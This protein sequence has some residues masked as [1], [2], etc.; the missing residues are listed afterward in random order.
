[1]QNPR[2]E[3]KLQ[4]R[5]QNPLQVEG[6]LLEASNYHQFLSSAFERFKQEGRGFSY[7]SFARKANIASRSF[8]R[9]VALEKKRLTHSS[10]RA[11]AGALG[12]TGDLR[13]FFLLLVERDEENVRSSK[14][15]PAQI[16]KQ[17]DR[18]RMMIAKKSVE[19]PV[20]S[21][22]QDIF[23]SMIWLKIYSASGAPDEGSTL[24]EIRKRC[25]QLEINLKTA[26]QEMC[27]KDIL[28]YN[29]ATEKYIPS[30]SHYIFE[31]LKADEFF[32]S[33]YLHC[34]SECRK[35]VATRFKS[36][37]DLY[38]SSVFSV[39]SEL[40]PELRVKLR[41]VLQ[42]FTETAESPTGSSIANL[43]VGFFT[44]L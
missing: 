11:F 21:T 36:E 10:A 24:E 1:M 39:R 5:M 30:C 3:S 32:K 44:P 14:V 25:G 42:K 13:R 34:L 35:T 7:A 28:K 43:I 20:G 9:D 17:L 12:L 41:E 23:K 6:L 15:T 18:L 8:P 33:W 27:A 2:Q 4:N 16:Q 26:L 19:R 22:P 38:F 37:H 31:G 40:M 29:A